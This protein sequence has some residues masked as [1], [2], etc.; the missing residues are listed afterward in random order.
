MLTITRP[1]FLLSTLIIFLLY[2]MSSDT[3]HS[4]PFPAS[5]PRN[6]HFKYTVQKGF[7]LQSEN[8]TDDTTF[9]FVRLTV[10]MDTGLV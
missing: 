8:S 1:I 5:P 7:F 9:D 3:S 2:T 10:R 4:I 6:F